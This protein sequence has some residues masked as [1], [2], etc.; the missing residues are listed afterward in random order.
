MADQASPP[1]PPIYSL[2]TGRDQEAIE[3]DKVPNEPCIPGV[4][5]IFWP[6]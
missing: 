1:Q 3:H 4:S 5:V 2:Q 6:G